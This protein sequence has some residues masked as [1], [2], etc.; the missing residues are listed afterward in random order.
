MCPVASVLPAKELLLA[1]CSVTETAMQLGFSSSN[2]FSGVFKKYV[3]R[4]PSEYMREKRS[5]AE[6]ETPP[7]V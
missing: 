4:T 6:K 1:G 7:G 2:Y 3:F 5:A